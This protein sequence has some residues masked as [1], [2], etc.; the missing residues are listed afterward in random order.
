M[1]VE[2]FLSNSLSGDLGY[3]WESLVV[4]SERAGGGKDVWRGLLN[5]GK[6]MCG[7]GGNSYLC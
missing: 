7:W 2:C 6:S 3:D 5:K 4:E 1:T